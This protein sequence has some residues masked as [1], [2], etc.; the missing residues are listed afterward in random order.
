VAEL[1]DAIK[2]ANTPPKFLGEN[3]DEEAEEKDSDEEE[4]KDEDDLDTALFMEML[5]DIAFAPP[6]ISWKL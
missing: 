4:K 2:K 5:D 1:D 6:E 3:G